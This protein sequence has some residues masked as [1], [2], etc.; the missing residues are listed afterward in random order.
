MPTTAVTLVKV[1]LFMLD[2]G[3]SSLVRSAAGCSAA[4][5]PARR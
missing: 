4:T 1:D 2:L 5:S 3:I